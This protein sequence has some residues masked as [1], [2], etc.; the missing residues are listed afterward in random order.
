MKKVK[1]ACEKNLEFCLLS[2]SPELLE[3]I[4]IIKD[5]SDLYASYGDVDGVQDPVI[6][7]KREKI[8]DNCKFIIDYMVDMGVD[9]SFIET[10]ICYGDDF[11]VK[12][13]GMGFTEF[14]NRG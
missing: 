6:N 3:D 5:A 10:F 13:I 12:E 4:M 9:R 1:S 2:G 14:K 7:R 11:L 8:M